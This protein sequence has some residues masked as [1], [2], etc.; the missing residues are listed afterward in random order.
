MKNTRR[1]SWIGLEL[2]GSTCTVDHFVFQAIVIVLFH[3]L[4]LLYKKVLF[5]INIHIFDYPDPRLSGQFRLVPTSRD[6]RGS[7]VNDG[8]WSCYTRVFIKKLSLSRGRHI[9]MRILE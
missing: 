2:I 4:M 1:R 6:N 9:V 7:T 3:D 5:V 8:G